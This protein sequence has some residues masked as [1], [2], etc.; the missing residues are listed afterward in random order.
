MTN[1]GIQPW[2]ESESYH[3]ITQA[4]IGAAIAV[5]IRPIH[6]AQVFSYLKLSGVIVGLLI[7]FNQKLLKHGI[8]RIVN[9]FMY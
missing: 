8:Y 2:G 4:I 6:H 5:H 9:G 3:Q 1:Q 7:N